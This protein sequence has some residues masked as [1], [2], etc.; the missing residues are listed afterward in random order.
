VEDGLAKTVLIEFV[1]GV[2]NSVRT[3]KGLAWTGVD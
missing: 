3:D 1:A 2:R